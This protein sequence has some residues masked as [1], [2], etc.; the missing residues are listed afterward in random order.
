VDF[1]AKL[2]LKPT[3][4][5]RSGPRRVPGHRW[6]K[7]RYGILIRKMGRGAGGTRPRWNPKSPACYRE[8]VT[9][10][11]FRDMDIKGRRWAGQEE[12]ESP[13][14]GE[15]RRSPARVSPARV[16]S[17]WWDGRGSETDR[18]VAEARGRP[19][20]GEK[21]LPPKGDIPLL[22]GHP[23]PKDLSGRPHKP[24]S[25]EQGQIPPVPART[26]RPVF[27]FGPGHVLV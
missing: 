21:H 27:S 11:K 4:E 25:D 26:M 20:P 24:V 23:A 1:P 7:L 6:R 19:C 2:R 12:Q 9:V 14:P 17:G 8:S 18:T 3:S 10:T 15:R 22:E 5:C 13:G 16:V